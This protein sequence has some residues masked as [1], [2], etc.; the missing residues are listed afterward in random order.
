MLKNIVVLL[1]AR[2]KLKIGNSKENHC[3][4]KLDCDKSGQS[5]AIH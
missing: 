3:K 5:I 1:F 4:L 2:V